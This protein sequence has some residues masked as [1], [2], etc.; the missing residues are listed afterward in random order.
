M[1][2]VEKVSIG[3]YAFTL[4]DKAYA[5]LESYMAELGGFYSGRKDGGEIIEAV[6]ERIAEHLLD[7][8]GKDSV[9]PETAVRTIIE[10]IGRPESMQ[11]GS[12]DAG[13][14]PQSAGEKE[15]WWKDNPRK[16]MLRDPE[17]RIIGGVCSG[18]AAYMQVDVVIVR[19]VWVALFVF[20]IIAADNWNWDGFLPV[21]VLLYPVLWV[22]VP[23]PTTMKEQRMVRDAASEVSGSSDFWPVL[24]K[25]CRLAFGLIFS[26]LGI[27][28]IT[29][30]LALAFSWT[31]IPGLWAIFP[32][33]DASHYILYAVLGLP[34]VGF[35][36]EGIRMLFDLK[37]L[38]WHPGLVCFLLWFA[39]VIAFGVVFSTQFFL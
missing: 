9:I 31:I 11:D 7:S 35:L 37:P 33:S 36:W 38:K 14:A 8:C 1:N 27:C 29:A 19:L 5:L 10:T 26:L 20:G 21:V 18:L 24:G 28:M 32:E 2:R 13:N 3:G 34:A 15:E 17:H 39:S 16:K 23:T 4:D 12:E 30:V 25:A 22:I 6:E